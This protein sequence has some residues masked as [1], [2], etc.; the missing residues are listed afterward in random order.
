MEHYTYVV[1][2]DTFEG[3][4]IPLWVGQG[5][6]GRWKD[7]QRR[8]TG[9]KDLETMVDWCREHG[10]FEQLRSE[11]VERFDTR[12]E[13]LAFE[14]KLIAL[15][16]RRDLGT[17]PL[18]NRTDGGEGEMSEVGRRNM[19]RMSPEQRSERIRVMNSKLTREQ[20]SKN[21]RAMNSKLTPEQ[22]T[23]G[24]RSGA[25]VTSSMRIACI[26]PGCLM[27]TN[28]GN[29]ARHLRACPHRPSA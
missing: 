12:G 23:K 22:R 24:R 20:R 27:V 25:R 5:T 14:N 28:P 11:I 7:Y 26:N 4:E 18:F 15:Y 17:G 29:M 21:A 19:A 1:Y 16:G 10:L 8:N 6:G 3:E 13:A 9:N 2:L